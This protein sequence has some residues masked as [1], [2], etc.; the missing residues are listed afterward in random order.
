M[1]QNRGYKGLINKRVQPLKTHVTLSLTIYILTF[2]ESSQNYTDLVL[3]DFKK[4]KAT[5]TVVSVLK[6][7]VLARN[8]LQESVKHSSENRTFQIVLCQVYF[9]L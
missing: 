8:Y 1:S 4:K 9:L 3:K 2:P 5:F 7:P 6:T